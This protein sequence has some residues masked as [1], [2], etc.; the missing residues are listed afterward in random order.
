MAKM[1]KIKS[2]EYGLHVQAG[3]WKSRPVY[4]S[5]FTEGDEVKTHHYGGSMRVGVGKDKTCKRGQYLELWCTCGNSNSNDFKP[6]PRL[7]IHNIADLINWYRRHFRM[8][9]LP[10]SVDAIVIEDVIEPSRKK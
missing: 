8:F 9:N 10:P 5:Q 7:N 2:D 4:E 1:A 6:N 3:G